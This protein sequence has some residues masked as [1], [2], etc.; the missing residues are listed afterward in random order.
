MEHG[1]LS[2]KPGQMII[3]PNKILSIRRQIVF[4]Q[5]F[6]ALIWN[7]P[8][9]VMNLKILYNSFL[10]KSFENIN[11]TAYLLYADNSLRKLKTQLNID[12][13]NVYFSGY[14]ITNN[15]VIKSVKTLSAPYY[16]YIHQPYVFHKLGTCTYSDEFEFLNRINHILQKEGIQLVIKLHPIE[17]IDKYQKALDN[18]I[19]FVVSNDDLSTWIQNSIAVI[20][21]YSTVLFMAVK[22][23]KPIIQISP[24]CLLESESL[25]MFEDVSISVQTYD[26]FE[27]LIKNEK[28]L[29]SKTREYSHFIKDKIGNNNSHEHRVSQIIKIIN[30]HV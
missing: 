17:E 22:Q 1:I 6:F 8:E 21:H 27:A 16:I 13:R 11:Y 3:P 29:F 23:N 14:P 18:T 2:E 4:F 15:N 26:S 7:N 9:K 12:E 19:S 24:S 25:K 30:N 28:L 5:K 10:K 20:G